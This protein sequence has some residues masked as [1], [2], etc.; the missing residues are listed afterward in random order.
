MQKNIVIV[1]YP[2]SGTTWLSRLV[3]EL[4]S[5]PLQGDWG[6]EELDAPYKEGL[7][8]ESE[9]QVYKSHHK[10][11][12]I[13]DASKLDIYKIIYIV[14]DP[15]DVVISGVHYFKFLPRLLAEKGGRLKINR[16]LR[17]TY[18]KL[19]SKKEKKRQMAEAVLNGNKNINPWFDSSWIDH[20]TS[21]ISKDI[22]II[23]YED[24]I[25]STET[26]SQN[27]LN[28]LGAEKDIL[29]LKKSVKNQSFQNRK[30]QDFDKKD[31]HQKNILRTGKTENWKTE[32]TE[33][34]KNLFKNKLKDLNTPY[35]F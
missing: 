16:V 7:E 11:E 24:L 23:K 3:A 18:N 25:N 9:F 32:L 35:D 20:F 8:R 30:K 12:E 21:Y 29:H 27:I 33:K 26:E 4:V 5:C 34:E 13:D 15:R 31:N 19:V 28:Y 10:F 2:K 22:L 17:K 1:G 6:F 14:R